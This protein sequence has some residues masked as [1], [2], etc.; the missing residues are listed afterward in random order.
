MLTL[1]DVLDLCNDEGKLRKWLR[2][3]GVLVEPPSLQNAARTWRPVYIGVS[4]AWWV[5]TRNAVRVRVRLGLGLGLNL[6]ARFSVFF[7]WI[8]PFYACDAAAIFLSPAAKRRHD[9][10]AKN[11]VPSSPRKKGTLPKLCRM[12]MYMCV[13]VLLVLRSDFDTLILTC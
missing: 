3:Y 8:A 1:F 12:F 13:L 4:L 10:H 6:S 9:I 11:G 5:Q 2:G 7:S